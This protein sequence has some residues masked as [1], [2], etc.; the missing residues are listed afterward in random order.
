MSYDGYLAARGILC[1]SL[2]RLSSV[3]FMIIQLG[4]PSFDTLMHNAKVGLGCRLRACSNALVD[5]VLRFADI[6]VVRI[7]V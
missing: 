2:Y 3:T 4:V 1:L 7:C 6:Q 5:I